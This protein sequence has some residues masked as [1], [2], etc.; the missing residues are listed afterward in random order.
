MLGG[1]KKTR[2]R[3]L[4]QATPCVRSWRTDFVEIPLMTPLAGFP[5]RRKAAPRKSFYSPSGSPFPCVQGVGILLKN[6]EP[7]YGPGVQIGTGPAR[8]PISNTS[9]KADVG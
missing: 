2:P 4:K 5:A 3:R 8:S 1:R 7:I 6:K 9:G